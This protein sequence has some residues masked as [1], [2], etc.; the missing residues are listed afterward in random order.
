MFQKI[1]IMGNLG[2][3]PVSRMLDSGTQMT[4]FSV[5]AKSGYGD[6]EETNWFNVT[7]FGKKAE[8]INNHF[9]KGKPIFIEGELKGEGGNPRTYEAGDGTVRASFD[10]K[11][12]DFKFMPGGGGQDL[13]AEENGD[14][15]ADSF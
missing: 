15:A 3:D 5:A 10:V 6:Y 14:S 4:T 13:Y 7:A 11:L 2:K 1:F 9:N 12:L 8:I